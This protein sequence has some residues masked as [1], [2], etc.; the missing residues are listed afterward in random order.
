MLKDLL[1]NILIRITA[2]KRHQ[3][4]PHA[5]LNLRSDL[6]DFVSDRS[7]LRLGKFRCP[8]A[9]HSQGVQQ[10]IRDREKP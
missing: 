3:H 6:Q 5:N 8:Q 1:E 2:G 7:A 9:K 4:P 10:Y